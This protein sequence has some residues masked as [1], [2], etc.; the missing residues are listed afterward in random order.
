MKVALIL[1]LMLNSIFSYAQV[2]T[3]SSEPFSIGETKKVKSIILNEERTLNIYLPNGFDKEKIYPVIY[4]LDGSVDEDILHVSGLVHFFN[5]MYEMPEFI[6]VGIGNV[7]RKRDFTFPTDIEAL[8]KEYPT[9]GHSAKFIEFITN[10]LQPYIESNY[11]T[12]STKYLIGQSLGG[13]LAC[14]ILLKKPELFTHYLITSPS[15]WW[16]DESL[17]KQ[18]K[19]LL[20]EKHNQLEYINITIGSK[21][22]RT[23]IKD[24]QD[25]YEILEKSKF[26]PKKLDFTEIPETHATILHASLMEAFKKLFKERYP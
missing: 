17:L 13:L 11:K 23:I 10:E 1:I 5:L 19:T 8:K 22:H 12:N 16:D 26:K 25:L 9:T 4:L 20:N 2:E 6:I 15:L 24:A 7:D 18:A 3:I 21:E 14:E